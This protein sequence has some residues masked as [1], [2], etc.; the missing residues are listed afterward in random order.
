MTAPDFER[1]VS[2][3]IRSLCRATDPSVVPMEWARHV[4]SL[5]L[6]WRLQRVDADEA[7]VLYAV[8]E[9]LGLMEAG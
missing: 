5:A 7:E 8:M 3:C 6:R 9:R 2:A 4:H 1:R